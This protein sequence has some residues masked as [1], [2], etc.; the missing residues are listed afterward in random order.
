MDQ[1]GHALAAALVELGP[2]GES[3]I[4]ADLQEGISQPP[5]AWKSSSFTILIASLA[6]GR[7]PLTSAASLP[8][9]LSSSKTITL[10]FSRADLADKAH[11]IVPWFAWGTNRSAELGRHAIS[12]RHPAWKLGGAGVAAARALRARPGQRRRRDCELPRRRPRA[13]ADRGRQAGEGA[14]LLLLH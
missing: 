5:S 2:A 3:L 12:P 13:A 6:F 8:G 4:R 7:G 10:A 14:H 1:G 9:D 11:K